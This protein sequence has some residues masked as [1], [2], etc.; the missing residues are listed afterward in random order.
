[1]FEIDFWKDAG[2]RAIRTAAQSI[3]ALLTGSVTGIL[4]VDWTQTL[5]ISALA[6]F[7]SVLMSLVATKTGDDES[8]S[9]LPER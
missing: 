2:E 5:S 8:A 6:A 4:D 7:L 9:F 1:M 3:I